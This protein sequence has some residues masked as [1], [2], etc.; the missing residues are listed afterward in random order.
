MHLYVFN[1]IIKLL[2]RIKKK[3]KIIFCS[4]Y[5]NLLFFLEMII[6]GK[7]QAYKQ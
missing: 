7:S 2:L 4:F 5:L 1:E 3:K 6:R